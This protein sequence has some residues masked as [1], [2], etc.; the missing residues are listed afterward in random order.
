MV[1]AMITFEISNKIINWIC[2]III[3]GI[4][5][6]LL[7]T[8]I[9]DYM[10]LHQKLLNSNLTVPL[11]IYIQLDGCKKVDLESLLNE[12]ASFGYRLVSSNGGICGPIIFMELQND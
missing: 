10:Q 5:L 3:S 12:Y 11:P 8:G 1:L 4:V 7:I 6:G 2:C 9:Y